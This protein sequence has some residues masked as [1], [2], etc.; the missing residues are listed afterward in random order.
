MPF[1]IISYRDHTERYCGGGQ[2]KTVCT[3]NFTLDVTDTVEQVVKHISD[4]IHANP[5]G[6]FAHIV[7]DNWEN[8]LKWAAGRTLD[9]CKGEEC[10]YYI[11]DWYDS[12]EEEEQNGRD[13]QYKLRCLVADKLRLKFGDK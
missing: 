7:I 12:T 4:N 2:Y 8:F 5:E 1:L 10:I 9:T 13:F 6:N 3:S 11:Y